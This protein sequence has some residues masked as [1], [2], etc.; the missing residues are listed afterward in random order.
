MIELNY[1]LFGVLF[2][3]LITLF[4]CL[5]TEEQYPVTLLEIESLSDNEPEKAKPLLEK[6]KDSLQL[7]N[8][9]QRMY[10]DLLSLKVK[11]KLY[12]CHTSNSLIKC[13][14]TFYE[15]YGDRDK[16]LESYYYMGRV[17]R[18]LQDSPEALKYFQKALDNSGETKRYQLL[19][20]VCMQMGILYNYQGVYEEVIPIMRK[21]NCYLELCGDSLNLALPIR[22]IAR[23]YDMTG[24]KDSAV[25]FYNEA[26]RQALRV[27]DQRMG[28]EILTELGA[29]YQEIEQYDLALE[30]LR[31]SLND[32]IDRDLSPSY[33]VLG[34]IYLKISQLDSADFYLKKC[35]DSDNTYTLLGIYR[36]LS[37]LEMARDSVE[38]MVRY[39]KLYQQYQDSI[40]SFTA[41][42]EIR[43]MRSLYNYQIRE[44]DNQQLSVEYM[45]VR[46]TVYQLLSFGL[47]LSIITLF[48]LYRMK[49]KRDQFEEQSRRLR[50]E[51]DVQN[52]ESL[53]QI[54]ENV[55]KI[56]EL[57]VLLSQG[58]ERED[59]LNIELTKVQKELLTVTN[60]RI[61][62][63]HAERNLLEV[64][65]KRSS[66]YAKFHTACY[67]KT[68]KISDSDWI[69]L[70]RELD[71]TYENMTNRLR[72]LNP[73]L[74]LLEIHLCY[75]IKL[76]IR[77]SL[78]PLFLN[79]AKSSIS[80]ARNNLFT[81]LTGKK[82]SPPDLDSLISDL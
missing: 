56:S 47:V 74:S 2:F 68:V 60:R 79:R 82:G 72:E 15:E 18:D 27:G 1:K 6:L 59:S 9:E 49:S 78:M 13:I 41:S 20:R 33:S 3:L 21:A 66:I 10:Y 5:K 31:I 22:D 30:S 58:K 12:I 80:T 57:G 7:L 62:L 54:K 46:L 44:R 35:L 67:D 38:N 76:S 55:K 24:K 45:K 8:E 19:A 34:R 50:R 40:E 17:Y 32:T 26:Y 16:L 73:G 14:T 64:N 65:L 48:L 28:S 81:K 29:V 51:K 61:E 43:K 11:D 37:E 39:V 75:L 52:K 70:G 69:N 23:M 36:N 63:R 25:F 77:V 4:S 71:L 53:A 42:M